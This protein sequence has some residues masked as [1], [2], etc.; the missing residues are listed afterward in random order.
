MN[1]NAAVWR[2]P[3]DPDRA[4]V[5][6][7]MERI[8]E[9]IAELVP[10]ISVDGR[11]LAFTTVRRRT[12]AG[13]GLDGFPEQADKLQVRIKDLRTGKESVISSANDIQWHPQISRD[14]SMVAYVVGKPGVIYAAP[15]N[16]GSPKV[17]V[18]GKDFFPWDWSLDNKRLLFSMSYERLYSLDLPSGS[19]KL[20]LNKPGFRLFQAKFSPDDQSVAVL[21]CQDGETSTGCQ[22]FLVRLDRGVPVSPD[23]W[24]A[25]SHPSQWDDK[26]RWSP[27]GK[28]IYFIS[29]RDG[30]FCLWAQSFN[31][32]AKQL[33]GAPFPVYH[34]HHARLSMAN[35][36]VPIAE[37][38]IAKDKIVMGLGELTGNLWSLK[39]K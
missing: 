37:I 19:K 17:V 16:G 25:I 23:L 18:G 30:Y 34:F 24:T 12:H 26:P 13:G 28:L 10:S 36:G 2:W 27:S 6:G 3:A 21:G 29:D 39:R 38:G 14:G 22:I 8:T 31:S 4:K 20:F 7:E 1:R 5:T 9:G 35:I 15:V 33:T 11:K 32:S